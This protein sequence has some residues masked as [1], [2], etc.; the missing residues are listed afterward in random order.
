MD[1]VQLLFHNSK[2][3]VLLDL[4]HCQPTESIAVIEQAKKVIA[5][6]PPKSGLVLTDVTEAVYTKD[7]ANAIKDFVSH[8][9]P[10]IKVSAVVGADG[11]RLV[12]LQSVIFITRREIKTFGA[13]QKAM[14]WLASH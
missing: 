4:S 2:Q 11:I 7:V 9:T 13:R 10:Y 5:R 3:I 6:L 8:N 1:R 12:L 14:D